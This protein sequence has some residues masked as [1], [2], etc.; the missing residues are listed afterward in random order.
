MLR[1]ELLFLASGVALSPGL[2][3]AGASL[4]REKP[5]KS[6]NKLDHIGL[7]LSTVTSLMLN[8]F[9]GTLAKI[10]EVGY[11]QVEF[12]AMGFLGRPVNYVQKLLTDNNLAAPVGRVSPAL[13][14]GTLQ[15]PRAEL[16]QVFRE[17]SKPEY[18]LENIRHCISDAQML[19]QKYLN[20][21]A[22]MPDNFQSIDQVKA[23][24]DLLNA[25]GDLCAKNG[26]LFGY[27]NHDWELKPIDGVIPFDLMLEQ[28]DD[29]KVGFQ[30]DAY[31]IVKGGGDLDSYLTKYP[32]R[33]P[34]CHMKDIDSN[35]DFA[36][37]GDGKIDFP[38]FTRK[39]IAQGSKYF[40]V[41]R[42]NPPAPALSIERSYAYLS[43]MMF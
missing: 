41:E 12:S 33:F 16:L 4:M 20:L 19:G 26:L 24:I 31:W 27:H 5:L 30:L 17:H 29:D 35:G 37:V 25:A 23:N 39:A 42:D 18:L 1:R 28:T 32:G 43:K 8:D 36:D 21:P 40:F 15:L 2:L 7:Q 3:G 14:E 38:A 22:L 34:S 6:S 9:E 11:D 10:S 13:P